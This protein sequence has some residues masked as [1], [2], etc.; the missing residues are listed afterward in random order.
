MLTSREITPR[1]F[2]PPERLGWTYQAPPSLPSGPGAEPQRHPPGPD[3]RPPLRSA[4]RRSRI[5]GRFALLGAGLSALAL[6]GVVVPDL[7]VVRREFLSPT[8]PSTADLVLDAVPLLSFFALGPLTIVTLIL[9]VAWLRAHGRVVG[10][11]RRIRRWESARAQHEA[12]HEAWRV[13]TEVSHRWFPTDTSEVDRVDVVGGVPAGWAALLTTW[14]ASMLGADYSVVVLDLTSDAVGS[15]LASAAAEGG[16]PVRRF[17]LPDRLSDSGLLATIPAGDLAEIV[18]SSAHA[19]RGGGGEVHRQLLD[20]HLL[21]AVAEQLDAPVTL[22]RLRA[23]LAVVQRT[24]VPSATSLAA[25]EVDR[26]V[27]LVDHLGSDERTVEELQLL[28]VTLDVLAPTRPDQP[29]PPGPAGPAGRPAAAAGAAGAWDQDGL[30]LLWATDAGRQRRQLVQRLAA[31]A[32]MHHLGGPRADRSGGRALIV[33][34]ADDLDRETLEGLLARCRRSGVRCLVLM[35]RLRQDS[36]QLIGEGGAA[37]A[38]MRLGN[39]REAAAAADFIGRGH[40]FQ[41][42]TVSVQQGNTV[43][44]SDTQ[45]RGTSH[46]VPRLRWLQQ[47]SHTTSTGT[48]VSRAEATTAG[49]V[50]A[51]VYDLTVEPTALQALPPTGFVLVTSRDGRRTVTPGTCDPLLVA[52]DGVAPTFGESPAWRPRYAPA[53]PPDGSG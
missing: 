14:G 46:S 19:L 5:L 1:L 45:S 28:R 48:G 26:L 17:P 2:V 36:E 18:A 42:T 43:T 25:A 30:T 37:V 40:R 32:L 24:A 50:Y 6:A 4:V 21:R 35:Q 47:R 8:E 10:H 53:P 29:D 34:G 52:V 9:A 49:E 39:G 44:R 3:P 16:V 7:G 38:F 11:R 13:R 12:E 41:L 20:A 51:R 23:G 31:H 27:E 15:Q 22:Q 33:A